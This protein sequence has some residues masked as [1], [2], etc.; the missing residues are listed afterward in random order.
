MAKP[1][2]PSPKILVTIPPSMPHQKDTR[3]NGPEPVQ[4]STPA[5]RSAGTSGE[6]PA[7]KLPKL[8]MRAEL[9]KMDN[10]MNALASTCPMTTRGELSR[11]AKAFDML[12]VTCRR[13][14]KEC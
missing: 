13:G 1:G 14:Q 10:L 4:Q 9:Q 5:K 6:E 2:P 12:E 3:E 7:A 11:L 8:E